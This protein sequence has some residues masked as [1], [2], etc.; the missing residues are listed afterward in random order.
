MTSLPKVV[1]IEELRRLRRERAGGEDTTV[2]GNAVP[3]ANADDPGP[4]GAAPAKGSRNAGPAKGSR[5]ARTTREVESA[6]DERA[7]LMAEMRE[8]LDDLPDV[9]MDKVIEARQRIATGF[10]D[11]DRVRLDILTAL[12]GE[13]SGH[14]LGLPP[15]MRDPEREPAPLRE[16]ASDEAPESSTNRAKR[17]NAGKR[18]PKKKE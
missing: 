2:A 18:P 5:D 1:S 4:R 3:E 16:P 17:R 6:A 13:E 8:A 7:R 11:K 14:D 9:R 10:Y 12:L 15:K